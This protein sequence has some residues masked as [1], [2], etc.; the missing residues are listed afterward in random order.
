MPICNK[1]GCLKTI[2][3]ILHMVGC[4]RCGQS[5]HA[6][7]LGMSSGAG[8]FSVPFCPTCAQVHEI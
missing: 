3:S 5:W 8:I 4:R 6:T 2:N 7:C 1:P